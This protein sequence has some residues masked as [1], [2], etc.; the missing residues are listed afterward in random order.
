R[1][2]DRV[3]QARAYASRAESV[4]EKTR[5]LIA[6]EAE[7]A[8]LRWREARNRQKPIEEAFKRADKVST[9][10]VDQFRKGKLKAEEAL[11]AGVLATQLHLESNRAVYLELQA[12]ATLERVTAGGFCA[13]LET[14]AP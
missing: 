4:S 8:V 13:D 7:Q 3:E 14:P 1:K 5:N 10:S 9:D 11:L 2:C 6:L 12:L